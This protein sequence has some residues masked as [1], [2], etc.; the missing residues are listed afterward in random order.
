ML[1]TAALCP[2]EEKVPAPMIVFLKQAFLPFC[3]KIVPVKMAFSK[4]IPVKSR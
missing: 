3:D 4:F 1:L 2:T